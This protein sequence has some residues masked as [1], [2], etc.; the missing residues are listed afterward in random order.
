MPFSTSPT[1]QI[2]AGDTP[3]F[4]DDQK[5]RNMAAQNI[6]KGTACVQILG[7]VTI[8]TSANAAQN[9]PFVPVETKD[10]S[11]GSPGDLEIKGVVADQPVALT[12]ATDVT[13]IF[14]GDLV[15]IS[16]TDAGQ[17]EEWDKATNDLRYARYW[18]KEA[19]VF[20][21]NSSTPFE[22]LLSTGVI[23]DESL[24]AGEVGWF[25]LVEASV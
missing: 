25:K 8:A 14:P 5:S 16:D 10:N 2:E 3:G 13:E 7:V 12:A 17:V 9:S 22:E 21:R 4:D 24:L 23:P 15:Q 11:A 18:G 19:G 20:S 1:R 6:L